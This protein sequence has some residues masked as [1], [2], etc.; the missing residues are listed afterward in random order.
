MPV[1]YSHDFPNFTISE[2][3]KLIDAKGLELAGNTLGELLVNLERKTGIFV[4]PND[5]PKYF[6]YFNTRQSSEFMLVDI[7]ITRGGEV[8]CPKQ[9][10]DFVL[11]PT[12]KVDAGL[13]G[14]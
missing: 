2:T 12:D 13:L 7:H 1:F 3:F 14:C 5:E 10:L 6:K 9:D 4:I 11:L 8:I